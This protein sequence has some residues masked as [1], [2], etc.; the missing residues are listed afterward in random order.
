MLGILARAGLDFCDAALEPFAA[1]Y[2]QADRRLDFFPQ[3]YRFILSICM[4]LEEL[5]LPGSM[6]ERL[7]CRVAEMRLAEAELSDLQRLEARRLMQRRGVEPLAPEIGLECRVRRFI[8]NSRSFAVPNPRLAYELSHVVFYLSE[9]GRVDP[10][11]SEQAALSLEFAGLI[12]F[13]D[14]NP[15]L[16][17]EICIAMR[18]AGLRPSPIWE[19][20]VLATL[21]RFHIRSDSTEAAPD[22]YHTYL[23]C[24]GLK[25]ELGLPI[26]V[27]R[28]PPGPIRFHQSRTGEGPLRDMSLCLFNLQ[29]DRSGEWH[30]MRSRVEESLTDHGR[31]TL[32]LA[33]QSTERFD[34]FFAGF[35][36]AARSAAA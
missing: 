25:I 8:D 24:N 11:L 2:R 30:R 22:D 27:E 10:R 9:D 17:A 29:D 3:Y 15:D 5:G 6:A 20:Q 18:Q 35:A 1:F 12:A 28:I 16:L 32:G 4:D 19:R 23:V 33:L 31:E 36:R 13:L 7:A 14:H 21:R 26:F 34:A